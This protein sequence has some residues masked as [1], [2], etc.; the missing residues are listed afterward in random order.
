MVRFFLK[1]AAVIAGLFV[2]FLVAQQGTDRLGRAKIVFRAEATGQTVDGQPIRWVA[3]VTEKGMMDIDGRPAGIENIIARIVQPA[4]ELIIEARALNKGP[5][6]AKR[7]WTFKVDGRGGITLDGNPTTVAAFKAVIARFAFAGVKAPTRQVTVAE[8][9]R[10][11]KDKPSPT[12]TKV[13]FPGR[14]TYKQAF[15]EATDE[16][17]IVI[18]EFKEAPVLRDRKRQDE[19]GLFEEYKGRKY[20]FLPDPKDLPPVEQ[21]L[22]LFPAVVVGPE[23]ESNGIGDYGYRW[24]GADE[25]S[26]VWRRAGI[27][28]SD[29]STK[30]GTESF[31]RMDPAGRIQPCLAYKWKIEN[32]N[33]V[34]TFYLRKG[35]KWSDGHPFTVQ[36]ILFVT[37]KII[38]SSYWP[39]SPMWMQPTDGST[40]L[41]TADILDWVRLAMTITRQG[42]ARE[43][44][45]GKQL[46]ALAGQSELGRE[47]KGML[48]EV[49]SGKAPDENTRVG[50]VGRLNKLFR[51]PKYY[52]EQAWA[53]V[54]M[55]TRRAELESRISVLNREE[56]WLLQVLRSRDDW[57]SRTK[58]G[59]GDKRYEKARLDDSELYRMNMLLFRA[60]YAGLVKEAQ[61]TRVKIEAVPDEDGDDTH[62]IR[63]TFRQPNS[64]FLEKTSHFMFYRGLFSSPRHYLGQF[65]PVGT[66]QLA[67]VDIRR[68]K[69]LFETARKQA[70]SSGD[71][72]GKQVWTMM[73]PA[74]RS[75][76]EAALAGGGFSDRLKKEVVA[77]L[78]R[79]FHRRDFFKPKAWTTPQGRALDLDVEMAAL[80]KGKPYI[81]KSKEFKAADVERYN[82][83]LMRRH[84]L[85]RGIDKLSEAEVYK[86]S[87]MMFRAA[88]DG[89]WKNQKDPDGPVAKSREDALNKEAVVRGWD[90]WLKRMRG[91][92]MYRS[93][94]QDDPNM[95]RPVLQAWRVVGES[96]QRVVKV[97]RNPY[98]YKVDAEGRQLPYIDVI[99]HE[100]VSDPNVRKIKITAGKIDMQA[101]HL[102]FTD[103][104]AL[105][106]DE[107]KGNYEVRLWAN[108]YCGE[109][110]FTFNQTVR[111]PA[112]RKIL[113]DPRFHYAMSQAINR[114]EMIDVMWQGIGTP[115]QWSVPKG[116]KYYNE[117]HATAGI[118]YD[119]DYA[120][121]LLDEM[122]LDK[123]TAGGI[124]MYKGQDGRW[125]PLAINVSTVKERPLD[126]VEMVCY[127]WRQVGVNCQMK[128]VSPT[129]RWRDISIGLMEIGVDKEG[130]NYFGPLDAGGFAPTHP[131]ECSQYTKWAAWLRSG[132]L[133][134]WEP[135]ERVKNLDR[136]WAKVVGARNEQE[137]IAAWQKLTENAIKMLPIIGI[138]TSPGKV[139]IVKNNFKNVPRLAL[140]GWIA[141]EPGNCC[142]E[143]FYM[144][145]EDR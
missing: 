89:L 71:S 94:G 20:Y 80:L 52:S 61:K 88:Y 70:A 87:Q 50:L 23:A 121:K 49:A 60:A 24:G 33:R 13:S 84:M 19:L 11:W 101:R 141:H 140:A 107:G 82:Y 81:S 124:R 105:K 139:V 119:P 59:P 122:G 117:R 3:S 44:S 32:E 129:Q 6:G 74:V 21:R 17:Q 41:S 144:V 92:G 132:G 22:P 72:P 100:K 62:I 114:Q 77:D 83:L 34:Y 136:Q 30:L 79:I 142:P 4:G 128:I 145:P 36:D 103:F 96:D 25:D 16:P 53:K 39:D 10:Y 106:Q 5:Q 134:G 135:P 131:A 108:D 47:L 15:P 66:D 63:F 91:K 93:L 8:V 126:A 40:L 31:V 115:A 118:K 57:V 90:S 65:T 38:G 95:N 102:K 75:R 130:G 29:Y 2:L 111:D 123:R 86:L 35:H 27:Y 97:V 125:R 112:L 45:P 9:V 58:I 138:M 28:L 64:I 127:Y 68:W 42:Q 67:E 48:T 37:E 69:E 78:N 99:R 133:N 1:L 7:K 120:N 113:G 116:S 12:R 73:D 104:T 55:T 14:Y 46:W 43:P 56:L 54:D 85:A 76:V 109:L 26:G 143:V 98:Y 18:T 137:K 51:N 110:T